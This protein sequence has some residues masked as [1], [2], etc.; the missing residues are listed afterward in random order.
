MAILYK[1]DGSTDHLA[2]QRWTLAA[3]Q[4]AVGGYIEMMP[5]VP[6]LTLVLNENGNV[7]GQRLP[8]NDAATAVLHAAMAA[9]IAGHPDGM[10]PMD[11]LLWALQIGVLRYLPILRGDV[12]QLETGDTGWNDDTA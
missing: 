4:A 11:I 3:L 9:Q 5:G 8:V 7:A 6:G 1:T 2:P 10:T 12:L